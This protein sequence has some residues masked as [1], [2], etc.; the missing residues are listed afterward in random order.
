MKFT[1]PK[2]A[3]NGAPISAGQQLRILSYNIQT[4]IAT[5]RYHHYVT[6]SWKHLLPHM[7]RMENL[8]R[9][10]RMLG[11]YDLVGLQEVDAGSLRSGFI[12]QTEYLAMRSGFSYWH[13]KTNRNIG[14]FAKHSMGL[15]SRYPMADVR[16]H[17]LP[18]LIPGRGALMVV[19]ETEVGPLALVL[20][21]LALSR[22]ARYRQ[23]EF[24]ADL[25]ADYTHS[26][27][28]GDMNC[29]ATSA[30]LAW[31]VKETGFIEPLDKLRTFPSWKPMRNI[32]HILV[33][34]SLQVESMEV[35]NYPLSDH[36]PIEVRL[37]LPVQV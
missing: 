26:I 7:D 4:G 32:D 5:K 35:L 14:M 6:H 2:P 16:E 17:K 12:N 27:I 13:N 22:R 18:G 25:V 1:R 19:Y 3:A 29:E 33:S 28:M 10:S 34:P 36:L 24:V 20:I 23:L 9:I 30:E 31:L 37:R 21:H 15:L 11:D 8:D